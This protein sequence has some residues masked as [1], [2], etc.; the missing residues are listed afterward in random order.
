MRSTDGV[1]RGASASTER[2][3]A[4]GHRKTGAGSRKAQVADSGGAVEDG[5]RVPLTIGTLASRTL[6]HMHAASVRRER[7]QN[8]FGYEAENGCGRGCAS[9][10]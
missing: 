6:R 9:G 8:D 2:D 3:A 1:G 7:R 5:P 10:N 4:A